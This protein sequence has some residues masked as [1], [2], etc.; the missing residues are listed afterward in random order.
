MSNTN[1]NH[2]DTKNTNCIGTWLKWFISKA[3]SDFVNKQAQDLIQRLLVSRQ[4]NRFGCLAGGDK[5]IR[6]HPWFEG[7][8][9]E[10]LLKKKITAPWVPNIKD[11]LDSQHFDSY[12]HVEN[13]APSRKPPL[14]ARQQ[15]LFKDF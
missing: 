9:T 13:E 3:S 7:M 2:I 15:Q 12:K 10:K 6:D 4:S 14:S 8:S 5:D 11:P 1:T